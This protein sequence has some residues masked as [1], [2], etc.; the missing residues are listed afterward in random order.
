MVATVLTFGIS[1]GGCSKTT[2]AGVTGY[3]LSKEHKV[4]VVDMDSQGNMTSLLTGVMDICGEFEEKTILEG[5]KVGDVRPYIQ[6]VTE[7]LHLVPSNDYL[8]TLPRFLY[9][10]NF[11]GN[12]VLALKEALSSVMNDYD[13][14]ILDTAPSLSENTINAVAASDYAV[15]MFDGSQFCYYAIDKFI[16]IC[17]AAKEKVGSNVQV[18]GI[19]FSIV[20][21]RTSDTKAMLELID[22]EYEGLRFE[23]LI[24]RKA[25]TKRLPIYGFWENPELNDAL[26]PYYSF[27]EELKERVKAT[28]II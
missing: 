27:V 26:T 16:E 11:S 18:A 25:A 23:T 13:F 21:P 4:L 20:D 7:T 28:A 12:P 1:K 24:K 15:V 19:L 14:I 22:S 8:A 6:Q 17:E 5:I 10:S 2:S 9:S 3:L